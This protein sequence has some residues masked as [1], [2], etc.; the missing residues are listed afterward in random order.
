MKV[1]DFGMQN[2]FILPPLAGTCPVCA[3]IH[4]ENM[5]HNRDSLYYQMLFY[6]Q[7]GRFPTW[8]DAMAH[9]D[10]HVQAVW[11]ALLA[12]HAARARVDGLVGI[13]TRPEEPEDGS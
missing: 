6:Q 1:K 11:M 3:A 13:E 10:Q 4:K 5:P 7:N 12:T 2:V 8:A 9:C